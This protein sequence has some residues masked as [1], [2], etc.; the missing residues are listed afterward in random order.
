MLLMS[1]TLN[2]RVENDRKSDTRKNLPV[3][4]K[5]KLASNHYKKKSNKVNVKTRN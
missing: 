1:D 2:I 3:V 4:S 5:E